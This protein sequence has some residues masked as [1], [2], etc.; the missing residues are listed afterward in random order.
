MQLSFKAPLN[1]F[2]ISFVL[3]FFFNLFKFLLPT[4]TDKK[5]LQ[6]MTGYLAEK[7][8]LGRFSLKQMQI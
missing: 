5:N 1:Y 3:F 6:I 2:T 7:L 8:L 4:D